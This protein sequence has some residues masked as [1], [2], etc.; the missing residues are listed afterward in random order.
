MVRDGWAVTL[1]D[2]TELAGL[3]IHHM[4]LYRISAVEEL[5]RLQL[6]ESWQTAVTLIEWAERLGEYL[7]AEHLAV[8]LQ[9]VQQVSLRYMSV[10]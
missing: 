10:V 9:P 7:P 8:T 2:C 5:S 6:E 4:D 3:P 1:S